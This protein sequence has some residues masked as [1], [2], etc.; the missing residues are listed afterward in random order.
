MN[1]GS[2]QNKLTEV[3]EPI[4]VKVGEN[5][6]LTAITE[7]FVRTSPITL[8]IAIFTIIGNFPIQSWLDILEKSGLNEH[9][10]ALMELG[11][12]YSSFICNL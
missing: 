12:K 5:K 2:I 4:A 7:G 11:H 1:F 3:L 10:A 9:F 6:T 8:G